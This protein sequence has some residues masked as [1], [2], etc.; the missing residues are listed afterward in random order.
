MPEPFG[1]WHTLDMR[2]NR[3]V[4]P[5]LLARVF[6]CLQAQG[7]VRIRLEVVGLDSTRV[8][9]PPG[10]TGALKK[11]DRRPSTV[12]AAAGP[13]QCIGWPRMRGQ[14]SPGPCH[15][16]PWDYDRELDTRRNE[17]ARRF[18][19]LKGFRRVYTRCDKLAVMYWGFFQFALIVEALRIV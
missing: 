13:P 15:R 7:R 6:T 8:P 14:R 1:P 4:R 18:R 19:R 2:R 11:T 17:A 16:E 12:P 5:G 9:V 10:G 3:W